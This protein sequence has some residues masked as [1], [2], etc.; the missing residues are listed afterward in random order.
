[1]RAVLDETKELLVRKHGFSEDEQQAY[2][3]KTLKRVTDPNLRDSCDRV[4]RGPLRKL[5]RHERFVGP[6][7]ELAEHGHS[8]EHLVKA[9]GAA[10]RFDVP[11]DAES[12][13]LQKMLGSGRS[14]DDLAAEITGLDAGHPLFP[15]VVEVFEHRLAG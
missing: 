4:G 3:D 5:S 12:V 15:S 6:A 1:V 13:E 10:L 7:A 9:I 8:T 14:A 11:E 2:I